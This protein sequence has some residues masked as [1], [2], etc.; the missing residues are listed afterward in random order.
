MS[1]ETG[2]RKLRILLV[3]DQELFVQSMKV[4][5]ENSDVAID[6]VFVAHNAREA[7]ATV[8]RNSIDIILLDIH[9]PEVD[10][11]AVLRRIRAT[12]QDI[13]VI[14]LSAFGYD[15]YVRAA[16]EAGASG[17]LLKDATP[18][19]V[20]GALEQV[21]KGGVILSDDLVRSVSRPVTAER[22]YEKSPPTWLYQLS[23]KE[24][25]I[26]YFISQGND[27]EEIAAEM[28]M[29]YQTIR[30]YV[31]AIYRKLGVKNRFKAMRLAIEARI[32]EYVVD[33]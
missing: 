7:Y 24:R 5:L 13:K 26:L 2:M 14:M 15:E 18:E 16:I 30:N 4:V 32:S 1:K 20:V 28:N 31:S 21:M 27:N 10:G 12:Q 29:A 11:L 8:K 19:L 23:E 22:S 3:D 17:Y 25:K 33:L 9:M 6:K